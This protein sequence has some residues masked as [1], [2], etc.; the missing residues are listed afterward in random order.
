MHTITLRVTDNSGLITD[1]VANI[2]LYDP[3]PPSIDSTFMSEL[4]VVVNQAYPFSVP[5]TDSESTNLIYTWDFD[6]DK[7]SDG[8]GVTSNDNEGV[9]PQVNHVFPK[10]GVFWVVCTIENDEG[11]T[12]EAEILVTVVSPTGNSE[13][14]DWLSIITIIVVIAVVLLSLI[15]I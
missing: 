12:T 4:Q 14:I 7:D 13:G 2:N 11:L 10:A 15:H 8:D 1:D 9:G 6:R 5:A 3:T